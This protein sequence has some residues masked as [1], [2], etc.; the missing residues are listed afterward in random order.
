MCRN[1]IERVEIPYTCLKEEAQKVFNRMNGMT[2]ESSYSV[3]QKDEYI[4]CKMEI[5]KE[6]KI[7]GF[8]KKIDTFFCEKSN[9]W[10]EQKKIEHGIPLKKF[11]ELIQDV[12]VFL[13]SIETTKEVESVMEQFLFYT[14]KR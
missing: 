1:K 13:V 11:P 8:L 10:L 6:I 12:Y 14:W 4:K 7:Q 2:E 9:I 5:E 3:Y